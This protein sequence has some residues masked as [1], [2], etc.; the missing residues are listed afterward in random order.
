L[1][2][3]GVVGLL[4]PPLLAA[5][6]LAM[7]AVGISALQ[8]VH[9]GARSTA[10]DWRR[11]PRRERVA[12]TATTAL[13]YLIQPLARL[14]G[15]VRHGLTPWRI[16]GPATPTALLRR[17]WTMWSEEWL[18][19]DAWLGRMEASIADMQLVAVRGGDYDAWD[20]EVRGGLLAGVRVRAAVEEHGAGRQL[21]RFRVQP[22]PL[23]MTLAVL[24][25]FVAGAAAAASASSWAGT[26]ALA[27]CG[28]LIAA[29]AG[30]EC[31]IAASALRRATLEMERDVAA[32]H[33]YP[34]PRDS[35]ALERMPHR[36]GGDEPRKRA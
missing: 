12:R 9:A 2:A 20:L 31:L 15:R 14:S 17:T 24:A 4:W 16:R 27:L 5:L 29:R 33:G 21:L 10:A 7:L 32:E 30:H 11:G 26:A 35:P 36:P 13:L 1:G 34:P 3:V 23:V 22:R 25:V 18:A 8:A 6:A 28:G 19:F